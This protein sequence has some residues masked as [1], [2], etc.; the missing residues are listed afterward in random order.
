MAALRAMGSQQGRDVFHSA[1]LQ[2]RPCAVVCCLVL[3]LVT[4]WDCANSCMCLCTAV[5]YHWFAVY[6]G[7]Y[8]Q[9]VAAAAVH[10]VSP[11][12]TMWLTGSAD[13]QRLAGGVALNIWAGVACSGMLSVRVAGGGRG[14]WTVCTSLCSTRA[15]RIPVCS[16]PEHSV[17]LCAHC[18][19]R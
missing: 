13:M 18:Y 14:R 15:Q 8:T 5:C 12:A 11:L 19:A 16:L 9:V 3:L 17:S 2:V 1:E 10:V 6:A 4:L 7:A